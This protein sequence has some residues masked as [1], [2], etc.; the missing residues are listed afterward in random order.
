M[1]YDFKQKMRE[2]RSQWAAIGVTSLS[3][4][5]PKVY[6]K[7]LQAVSTLL[8]AEYLL[9]KIE[10]HDPDTL[11]AFANR[12]PRAMVSLE[13]L[14]ALKDVS[15]KPWISDKI[16]DLIGLLRE[17]RK[18]NASGKQSAEQGDELQT[19]Y[20]FAREYALSFYIRGAY[21]LLQMHIANSVP[22]LQDF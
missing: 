6:H 21:D 22:T 8:T 19:M 1:T 14:E 10:E 16:D 7:Y 5:A 4:N 13:N 12:Q 20:W 15:S 18:A 9:A 3:V 17:K 11:E 2:N